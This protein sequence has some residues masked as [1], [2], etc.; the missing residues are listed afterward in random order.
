MVLYE[1]AGPNVPPSLCNVLGM[2][3]LMLHRPEEARPFVARGLMI[4]L[5]SHDVIDMA[6]SLDASAELAFELGAPERAMRIKGASDAI[7]RRAGS[8]PTRLA[9]A[10]RERWVS[11]AERALGKAAHAAWLEGGKLDPEEAGAYAL[12][13]VDQPPPRAGASLNTTLS[14]R[15]NQ[16]AELVAGGLTN[17][18]IAG[19]LRLSRRTVEA[20][21]DHIRT[22][23]GVR[24]R[25]E[26]ATWVT[27]KATPQAALRS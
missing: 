13:P 6:G 18:E 3:L 25:V 16:V 9:A 7:R 1:A 19:R 14:G 2:V 27:A 15:E 20:H 8:S 26:V 23:L 11:H 10:S 17:D 12:T 24:S 21:L 5:Q 4:R 22:K